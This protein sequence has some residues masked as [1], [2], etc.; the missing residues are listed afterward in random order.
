MFS[1]SQNSFALGKILGILFQQGLRNLSLE[2][3]FLGNSASPASTGRSVASKEPT[4]EKEQEEELLEEKQ[5]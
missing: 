4:A 5:C 1:F 2:N 3:C